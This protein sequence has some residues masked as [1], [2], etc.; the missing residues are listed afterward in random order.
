MWK[1]I[2]LEK[3][4]PGLGQKKNIS[5]TFGILSITHGC[6]IDIFEKEFQWGG[7]GVGV[8]GG[9]SLKL[10]SLKCSFPQIF[11]GQ[12]FPSKFLKKLIILAS[13]VLQQMDS[14][15]YDFLFHL[16]SKIAIRSFSAVFSKIIVDPCRTQTT[17]TI[18][19]KRY[20]EFVFFIL[21]FLYAVCYKC[22]VYYFGLNSFKITYEKSSSQ[23]FKFTTTG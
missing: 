5:I 16:F 9:G 10:L 8:A 18:K 17:Q 2:F 11:S 19:K 6:I 7:K 22:L 4:A 23:T 20:Q 1:Y 14:N 3:K 12:H 13:N 21:H 15:N